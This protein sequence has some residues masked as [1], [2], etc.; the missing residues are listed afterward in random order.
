MK[1]R[2]LVHHVVLFDPIQRSLPYKGLSKLRMTAHRPSQQRLVTLS[3]STSNVNLLLTLAGSLVELPKYPSQPRRH[4]LIVLSTTTLRAC[5]VM[6]LP[7]TCPLIQYCLP[8]QTRIST[9][10]IKKG[11]PRYLDLRIRLLLS[12]RR[13]HRCTE[14]LLHLRILRWS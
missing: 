12:P 6:A 13:R 8:L 11:V 1:A 2:T 14:G 5:R 10:A 3:T 9:R 4:S 7:R